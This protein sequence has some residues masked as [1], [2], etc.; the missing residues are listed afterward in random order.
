M[1]T[2]LRS[3][4]MGT[5]DF[6]VPSLRAVAEATSLR[7]VVTQPDRPSGRGRRKEPPPVKR[8]AAE[9]G[10]ALAQPE[11][12]KGAAFRD[13]LAAHEPDV[14]VTAA[15]GRI[16]GRR[17]LGLPRLGCLNV[18]ASILPAYRG[19]APIAWAIR[20][21]EPVTGVSI[22]RMDEGLDT[23]PLYRVGE[24]PILPEETAGE[25]TIRL[26]VV[27]AELLRGVL[28]SLPDGHAPVPQDEALATMAPPLTK[29]DGRIDWRLSAREV[30]A[31]VRA[32]HPWPCAATTIGGENAKVHRVAVL[33]P[34]GPPAG[35]PGEVAEHSRAG[36]DVACGAG[37]VRILDLQMP[38]KRR[39]DAASFH[40]GMRL[41]RGTVLG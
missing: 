21:G 25:L 14:V 9:L 1:S 7:L 20:R 23:G 37:V 29:E 3:I 16:L 10:V 30:H 12:V 27:G 19:A 13:L 38:G 34:D 24:I 32:M 35:R 33:A 2:K 5:P 22:M 11:T 39:L 6:A 4:F 36:V 31:H 8:A 15:F 17:A 41:E 28:D 40:A 26:A 18:H